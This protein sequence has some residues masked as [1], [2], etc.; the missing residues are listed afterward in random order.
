MNFPILQDVIERKQWET[1][2]RTFLPVSVAVSYSFLEAMHI[3]ND[4]LKAS[5]NEVAANG[6][7]SDVMRDYCVNL[8]SILKLK[9]PIQ[10][11]E[12]WK[13]EA[14][15]GI[16]CSFVYRDEEAFQHLKN[17][18]NKVD[19][20]PQSL[21]LAY[22]SAGRA[23]DSFLSS[24]EVKRLSLR[25]VEKGVTYEAALRMAALAR[26]EQDKDI[27][28]YWDEKAEEAERKMLHTPT[29]VPNVLKDVFEEKNG[30]QY[31]N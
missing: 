12:D 10:W 31:E 14:Y 22:I 23:F 16:I 30:C 8:M 28:E 25:A 13:N 20:P 4:L 29:I 7:L 11:E 19:D 21:L 18:Y 9:H 27:A 24:K 2:I 26:D 3:V 6:A 15:L 17:A 1:L 5:S